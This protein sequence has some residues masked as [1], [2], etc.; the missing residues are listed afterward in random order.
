MVHIKSEEKNG[1]YQELVLGQVVGGLDGEAGLEVEG[2]CVV[3]ISRV[4]SFAELSLEVVWFGFSCTHV[5]QVFRL[6]SSPSVL[7]HGDKC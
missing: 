3:L 4:H 2:D 6:V 5:K 7:G 1:I